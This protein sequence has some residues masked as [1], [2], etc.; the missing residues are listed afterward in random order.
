MCSERVGH[1]SVAFTMGTYLDTDLDA[2]REV[3][4]AIAD[5]ILGGM[6]PEWG[7]PG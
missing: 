5:L 2:D 4:R 6:G 1:A 3:A 7:P